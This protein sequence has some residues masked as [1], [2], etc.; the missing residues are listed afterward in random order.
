MTVV[1]FHF[2]SFTFLASIFNIEGGHGRSED[3]FLLIFNSN[4]VRF[5]GRN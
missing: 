2:V 1:I 3:L 5:A 4:Y